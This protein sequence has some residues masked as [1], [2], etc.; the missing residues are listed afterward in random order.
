[1]SIKKT[2]KQALSM[3]IAMSLPSLG[4]ALSNEQNKMPMMGEI[5]G[6]ERCFGINKAH[7]NDCSTSLHDCAGKAS[8]EG[9]PEEWILLPTG[10]CTK[11]R[12]GSTAPPSKKKA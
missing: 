7:L 6:M 2:I 3:I 9:D 12:G 1:M 11:I 8:K 10:L 5:H 4:L